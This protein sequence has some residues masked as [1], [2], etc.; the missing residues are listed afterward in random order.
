MIMMMIPTLILMKLRICKVIAHRNE[1]GRDLKHLNGRTEFNFSS[2]MY[3]TRNT[4]QVLCI[5]P[6]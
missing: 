4:C 3:I 5:L 1:K 2:I 6:L